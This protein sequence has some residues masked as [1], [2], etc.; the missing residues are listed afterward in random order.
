MNFIRRS[1]LDPSTT[2][3]FL[4]AYFCHKGQQSVI[5]NN[6]MIIVEFLQ[7]VE[8]DENILESELNTPENM[9]I[10]NFFLKV[11]VRLNLHL[12]L[13]FILSTFVPTTENVKLN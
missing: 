3:S 8:I 13:C 11:V 2:D 1:I 6:D 7:N 9:L 12:Q 10:N 4:K 5:S